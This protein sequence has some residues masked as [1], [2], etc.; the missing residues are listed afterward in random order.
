VED[1]HAESAAAGPRDPGQH[2]GQLYKEHFQAIYAYVLRRAGA[3]EASD[4]VAEVFATA[5]RRIRDLPAPPEDK[6]WLYGVARRVVLQ[7]DRSRL[8]RERLDTK[9]GRSVSVS[10]PGVPREISDLEL[11]V[12]R[13][14]EEMKPDDRELVRLI[15]WDALTHPEIATI[16]GC[17]ANAVAIRWHRALKRLRH[18]IGAPTGLSDSSTLVVGQPL[19]EGT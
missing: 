14:I 8:R 19:K 5:W 11:K 6:L 10:K 9:L 16:L 7:H 3:G 4:L 17:S 12:L 15:V 18:D 1:C 13:L 2:F